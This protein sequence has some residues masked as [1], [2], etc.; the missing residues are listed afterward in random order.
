MTSETTSTPIGTQIAL[1]AVA[2]VAAVS[3]ALAVTCLGCG[4]TIPS[5]ADFCAYC[6]TNQEEA[7]AERAAEKDDQADGSIAVRSTEAPNQD[8]LRAAVADCVELDAAATLVADVAADEAALD[9]AAVLDLLYVKGLDLADDLVRPRRCRLS[10]TWQI[11]GEEAMPR[12]AVNAC[13]RCGGKITLTRNKETGV[14]RAA[15]SLPAECLPRHVADG[16]AP[17]SSTLA[18]RA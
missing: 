3:S 9:A 15:H 18:A 14:Y 4:Q 17:H 11:W 12:C 10:P 7:R 5:S 2:A 13:E 16:F 1:P 8:A 6:G